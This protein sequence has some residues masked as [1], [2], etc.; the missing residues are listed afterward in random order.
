MSV[1]GRLEGLRPASVWA[2]A[3]RLMPRS[4]L[5]TDSSIPTAFVKAT[6]SAMAHAERGSHLSR[7]SARQLVSSSARQLISLCQSCHRVP[8]LCA[9]ISVLCSIC[10]YGERMSTSPL[11]THRADQVP[12]YH[13]NTAARS[14]H[15]A[16]QFLVV[17]SSN[18]TPTHR[19]PYLPIS[20]SSVP[21]IRGTK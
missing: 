13:R 18:P 11:L 6:A 16:A 12:T 14:F 9:L 21:S 5:L 17:L 4:G 19:T 15:T 2:H 20:R 1:R 3:S 10:R 8:S 7:P